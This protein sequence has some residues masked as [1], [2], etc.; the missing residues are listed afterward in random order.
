MRKTIKD[1]Q[2]GTERA[3]YNS[4][5]TD[6]YNITIDGVEDGE[7][8]FKECSNISIFDSLCNLRYPFWH[9]KNLVISNVTMNDTCRAALWY[10]KKVNI[11]D[12]KLLGIKALR[13]CSKVNLKNC[14]IDSPE[15]GWRVKDI[16]L[17]NCE[18]NATYLFFEAKNLNLS[19]FKM[20]GKYSFQYVKNV[21]IDNATL[22]TKDAFWHCNNVTVINSY[23]KGEYLGWYSNNLKFVNCKIEGTQPLCYCKN[24]QL[25]NCEMINCD[26]AFEKSIVDAQIIGH[27]DSIK[28]PKGGTILAGSIGDVIQEEAKKKDKI[29]IK[30]KK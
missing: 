18:I 13:E 30:T 11:Q 19:S 26:L 12:S 10:D 24:L 2:D 28:N 4:K 20:S 15:F 21:V 25:I 6:F 29:I 14:L 22:D 23:V 7:S 1:V 17:T 3:F 5:N 9:N 27:V 8:A 16:E